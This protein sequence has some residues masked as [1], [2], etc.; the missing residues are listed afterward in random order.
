MNKLFQVPKNQEGGG[1][2][3]DSGYEIFCTCFFYDGRQR[4][5]S[6]DFESIDWLMG[7]SQK[8]Q[9]YILL[10]S[11]FLQWQASQKI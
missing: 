1:L 10:W 3:G 11:G 7:S 2:G 4:R 5:N 9:K 6:G 8:V